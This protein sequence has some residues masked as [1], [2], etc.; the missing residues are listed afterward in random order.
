[1]VIIRKSLN[2]Y[3]SHAPKREWIDEYFKYKN[4][5]LENH[6]LGSAM[7]MRFKT[8][9]KDSRLS[10]EKY[11][12][13]KTA[14]LI[15]KI[16]LRNETSWAILFVNLSFK[17]QIN[18]FVK[19]VGFD[20]TYSRDEIEKKLFDS[21]EK[22]K[23]ILG[24]IWLC[25]GRFCD[26]PFSEVGMGTMT[27]EKGHNIEITRKPWI[28]PDPLII[29]YAIYRYSECQNFKRFTLSDL[30]EPNQEVKGANVGEIFGIDRETFKRMLLEMSLN[31]P[32]FINASFTN[33]LNSI[34]LRE[35]KTSDDVLQFLKVNV[36]LSKLSSFSKEE[37]GYIRSQISCR[38]K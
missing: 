14:E 19:N 10:D 27:K 2:R 13:S 4:E 36:V 1:M 5:F 31:Y 28:N 12:F 18:W 20:K 32:E 26:L 11:H 21:D 24:H 9:L 7:I 25:F 35:D 29:L 6:S 30:I 22:N 16:G 23:I 8:F 34:V 37:K 38:R 15:E 33:D 17:S 3:S